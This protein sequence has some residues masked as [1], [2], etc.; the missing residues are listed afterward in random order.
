MLCCDKSGS[1]R[2]FGVTYCCSN[3][4]LGSFYYLGNVDPLYGYDFSHICLMV[5]L[6]VSCISI[7]LQDHH[8]HFLER[9]LCLLISII[10]W[11]S[12]LVLYDTLHI[13]NNS[14]T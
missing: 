4:D 9:F 12:K 11:F 1:F 3:T 6:F 14:L 8:V 13:D 2:K 7:I 10:S 5:P